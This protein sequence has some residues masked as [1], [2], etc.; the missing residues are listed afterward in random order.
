MQEYPADG[1]FVV[2]IRNRISVENAGDLTCDKGDTNVHDCVTLH[3]RE[4]TA[5]A[6]AFNHETNTCCAVENAVKYSLTVD[7]VTTT[8]VVSTTAI[9]RF[10]RSRIA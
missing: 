1:D 7:T 5:T 2:C 10:P 8:I 9:T 3:M 6:V 4:G